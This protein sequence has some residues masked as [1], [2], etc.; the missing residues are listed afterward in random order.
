MLVLL[1]A[2][3][4]TDTH[5]ERTEP[6]GHDADG[7]HMVVRVHAV[8]AVIDDAGEL[9]EIHVGVARVE[10]E[11]LDPQARAGIGARARVVTFEQAYF[12]PHV[13]A[14]F[15]PIVFGYLE[16]D[17]CLGGVGCINLERRELVAL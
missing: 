16:S 7:N 15:I 10:I 3:L 12:N 11:C 13:L 2:E 6:L 5:L 9:A 4:S 14:D 1:E 8:H 17:G